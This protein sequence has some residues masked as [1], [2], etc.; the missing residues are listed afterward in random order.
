MIQLSKKEAQ[1]LWARHKYF[2]LTRSQNQYR[3]IRAYLKNDNVDY[4]TVYQMIAQAYDMDE[5]RGEMINC[6]MH[7]WGYFKRVATPQEKEQYMA[8]LSSYQAEKV[9]Q[10]SL[11]QLFKVL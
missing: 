6:A 1:Q 8:L 10:D 2:V 5:N 9:T 7:L 4:D 11:L 3:A